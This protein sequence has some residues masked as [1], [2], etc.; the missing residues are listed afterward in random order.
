MIEARVVEVLLADAALAGLVGDRVFPVVVRQ[1]MALPC[2]IY[3]RL[4]AEREYSLAGAAGWARVEIGLTVWGREYAE[5]RAGAD[6]VRRA[7]DGYGDEDGRVGGIE[8][9]SVQDAADAFAEELDAFGC[10]LTATVQW[11]EL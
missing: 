9:S 7:L 8:V 5:A 3:Q 6:A 10:G 1:E 2:V 4:A 11:A